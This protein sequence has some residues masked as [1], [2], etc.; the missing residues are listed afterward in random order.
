MA[1]VHEQCDVVVVGAGHAGC[2][3]ALACARLGLETIVFTVSVESIALMPCNPNI[4]G[5][6]KGHLVREVD[7][8]GGEM[9][10]NIDKTFI[11]SKMLNKSKG[12]AVHSLRAQADK[13]DYSRS[14]RKVLENTDHLTIK[15]AEV[16]EIITE[17]EKV[18]G[19]KTYSGAVY[20]S[21]AVV[22]ATGTY[23]RARC[24][25][26]DVSNA[27]G[28]NGLQAAN[29]LTESL[30]NIGI[31]MYRFKTGTPARIDRRSIDFSKMEEQFGD[32]V[33]VPFSFTTD[34]EDIQKEQVSCW[35]T[36]TNEKTHKI[37]RENIDR[38]PLFSGMIEGTGPR[39]C[40][41][42]EDKVVK[43]T[44]KDRHQVF[45]EP[46]GNYTNEMYIGGMSSSLPEDVQI[47]MYRSVAG[48]ENAKI[49]RNAYAIEYDCINP[50]ELRPTLEFKKISGLF[51]G[52][53]FN[54]SSGY[55]EAAAQGL[56]AG[57]NA[58][59]KVLGREMIILDRSQAYIGVL[60][61]DLVTKENHE[62][63]RMMT[64]RA[65]Y[66]LI[67]R[68]D[69]ADLRLTK[70]GYDVGLIDEKRY[71]EVILKE[72]QIND[73]IERLNHT[74]I[75]ATEK[76]QKLLEK[77]GST[78]LKTGTTMAELIR[79]PELSYEIL[80]EL[81]EKRPELGNE[82]IDQININIKYDGY[83]KR[84]LRAVEQFKKLE[85]KK[86]DQNFN[87]DCVNGLRKEAKQK[88]NL[89]KPVSIGQA[90]RIS[91]VSPADIS[92]LLVYLEQYRRNHKKEE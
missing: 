25:Y 73:E 2:E 84:Q 9:G 72:K 61:D 64:S 24:I 49:V 91:G 17:G 40:P 13:Q 34:P 16:T 30:K 35:L 75:G 39:Y 92:V 54:G 31:E 60:I 63:Y 55:E 27:T 5:S 57:I 8:L 11:Q 15:Q 18:K 7:A 85:K 51:S 1:A 76:V 70:I 37:I 21:K 77:F 36:Y 12:P 69:N 87:Y 59:M 90:S 44:D 80:K 50:R 58:A 52:G 48:L 3:A 6:S 89:Y 53:Q 79:R 81:D 28:P 86:L 66:R 82:I 47:A 38:S 42:I 56:V 43:F 62:P 45:I 68:Q 78:P 10:K 46:E 23:L 67:L 20:E 19:I 26:G 74:L 32:D 83:I 71:R 88:L 4:G 65:E 41:S 14:M 33:I 22:L 29:Y